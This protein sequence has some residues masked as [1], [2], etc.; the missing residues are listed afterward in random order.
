MSTT[1]I[2]T[3]LLPEIG[4]WSSSVHQFGQRE[5]EAIEASEITDRPLLV[6]GEPGLGK[7]QIA[8]AIAAKNQWAL[9]TF[10]VNA[11]TEIED[12]LYRIDHV[13]RLSEAHVSSATG[14]PL[15]SNLTR[16]IEHG[17]IWRALLLSAGEAPV[18]TEDC[19][20]VENGD[21]KA[22]WYEPVLP[23]CV[24]LID[25]V[26][27]APSDV[28]NALLEVL[29][30]MKFLVT[31]TSEV[32]A[33]NRSKLRIVITANDERELPA[34]F[35]RR[36]A[37]LQLSL[38]DDPKKRLCE[39]G[40]AHIESGLLP[41]FKN[42]ILE[43]AANS[44]L[45]ER[46]RV[47]ISNYRPG[48]SEYLDLLKVAAEYTRQGYKDDDLVRVMDKMDSYIVKKAVGHSDQN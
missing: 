27:K 24:L 45:K 11:R 23:G 18:H 7:S 35:I 43:H 38:G 30:E 42:N 33:G 21:N 10:V 34:A 20:P 28:P 44:V 47:N 26:D 8:R 40:R 1:E 3:V 16:F 9:V 15:D 4:S 37:V 19:Y 29:N 48:T 36:C 14:N 5:L 25:E 17:P 6:R 39:I 41:Q 13:R 12:L 22:G 32:V 2:N 31:P 46:E